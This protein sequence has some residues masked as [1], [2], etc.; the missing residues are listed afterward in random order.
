MILTAV[1]ALGILGTIVTWE[2]QLPRKDEQFTTMSPKRKVLTV[3]LLPIGVVV[4][5]VAATL[6][7]V[8]GRSERVEYGG[9]V[10]AMLLIG[11]IVAFVYLVVLGAARVA[12]SRRA[13]DDLRSD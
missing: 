13:P 5:A 1:L 8:A 6:V 9:A 4:I 12:R 10:L 7:V 2:R 11:L 3:L